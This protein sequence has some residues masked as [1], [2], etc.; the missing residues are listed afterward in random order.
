VTIEC[1]PWEVL[2]PINDTLAIA[3]DGQLTF[4]WRGPR[5]PHN[6][7]RIVKPNGSYHEVVVDLR[8]NATIDLAEDLPDAGAHTWYVYPLGDDYRQ[9]PCLEGG[10]W[11]FSK[12]PKP[13]PTPTL[14]SGG[15]RP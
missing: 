12:A 1:K 11:R 14:E 4:N 10:P 7:V 6:L 5:A 8:Q 13:T 3:G 15:L 2:T 9:I